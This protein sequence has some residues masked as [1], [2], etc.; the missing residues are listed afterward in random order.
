MPLNTDRVGHVYAPYR[1][2]VGR[3]HVRS[4]AAVTG[5]TDGRF[6][7][8]APD[9]DLTGT[10]VP[11]AYVACIAGARAWALVMEDPELGAHGRV[12]HGGQELAFAA[13]VRVGD[14]LV[15]TPTIADLRA[16]RNLE[17]LTVEVA[18]ARPDGTPVVTSRSRLVFVAEQ[19]D[20]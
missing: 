15:C 14:V 7:D 20:A 13:P 8:D 16:M 6:L 10:A 12:M 1:Y 17:L 19:T 4:Y 3:E 5:V 9:H 11:P 18:C 2:E